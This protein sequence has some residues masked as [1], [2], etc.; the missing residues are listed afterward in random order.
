MICVNCEVT[1]RLKKVGVSVALDDALYAADLL[2][3]PGCG[4]EALRP[5]K[6]PTLRQHD[7][8]FGAAVSSMRERGMLYRAFR[9]VR[10]REE[11]L[12][13]GVLSR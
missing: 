9:G 10:E 2:E 12:A 6:A 3:C 11:V 7:R 13:G 5:A 1:Y 4:H 8:N